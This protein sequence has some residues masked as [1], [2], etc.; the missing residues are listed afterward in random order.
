MRFPNFKNINNIH[1]SI[2]EVSQKAWC[3]CM[4]VLLNIFIYYFNY[5]ICLHERHSYQISVL[6]S[7]I[8]E[9]EHHNTQNNKEIKK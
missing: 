9:A 4:E 6:A 2:I 3:F 1:Q 7:K 8:W 5:S